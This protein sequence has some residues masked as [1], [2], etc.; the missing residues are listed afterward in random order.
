MRIV[1]DLDNTLTDEFGSSKRPFIDEFLQKLKEKHYLILWT[2][3]S[4]QRAKIILFEHDLKKY[5]SQF[6]FRED[7]DPQNKGVKKDITK[8]NA[9][10]IIDDDPDEIRYALKLKKKGI[11]ISSYRK[12]TLVNGN[13]LTSIYNSISG[14]R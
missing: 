12:G 5:F 14:I 6:I 10:V 1:I 11:L 3:S 8:V 4:S 7:Y 13:E 2:N 9:D